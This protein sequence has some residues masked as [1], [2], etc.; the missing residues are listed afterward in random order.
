M[1]SYVVDEDEMWTQV[2]TSQSKINK[3]TLIMDS[4]MLYFVTDFVHIG[5]NIPIIYILYETEKGK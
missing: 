5:Y 2:F 3:F 1:L 4:T